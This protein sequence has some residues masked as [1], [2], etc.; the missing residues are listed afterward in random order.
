MP[1]YDVDDDG[2]LAPLDRLRPGPDL[3]ERQIE[4]LLWA[5]P[6]AFVGDALFVVARQ[7]RI[8]EGGIPD[9]VAL[10]EDGRV[11]IIEVKRDIAR[12]QLAQ[13][14]EYAGWARLT[15]LDEIADLYNRGN[16]GDQG[17]EAF[18]R[19]WQ[20][21][22]ETSTPITIEPQP[23]LYLVAGDFEGRTR[24][25]LEFLR[26][27]FVPLAI[28]Q[29]TLYQDTSGRRVIDVQPEHEPAVVATSAP[30]EPAHVRRVSAEE[31]RVGVTDLIDAGFL[32]PDE[33]VEFPR[34]RLGEHYDATIRANGWFVLPDGTEH[35]SPSGAAE[36]AADLPQYD[37]WRAWRVPRLGG[38]TLRELRERYVEEAG[39]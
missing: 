22:T 10:D 23:R 29:V 5:D 4:D 27:N 25:A 31:R 21:F 28:V 38:T 14:L 12:E 9:I 8:S 11:V 16:G 34:P 33:P 24:S 36:Y 17:A 26:D 7:P 18:F 30:S 19:D 32:E 15:H 3:Y 13:A 1:L 35:R 37:G 2:S 39:E 6:E 20:N